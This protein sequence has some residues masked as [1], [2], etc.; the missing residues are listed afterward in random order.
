MRSEPI[1]QMNRDGASPSVGDGLHR[2]EALRWKLA[3]I[4]AFNA[5][6]L[7]CSFYVAPLVDDKQ[8]RNGIPL[9]MKLKLQ[10]QGRDLLCKLRQAAT[11]GDRRGLY[12]Q[13]LQ[14]NESL[15]L[16]RTENA[17]SSFRARC[18]HVASGERGM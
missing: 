17:E 8:F 18:T 16:Y 2:K 15:G 7:N 9:H 12:A 6:E 5:M 3:H 1:Y 14:V 4:T 11:P 10:E 13:L